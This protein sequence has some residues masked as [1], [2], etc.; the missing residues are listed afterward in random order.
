M[1]EFKINEH[2][3]LKLE[4]GI[5]NIYVN[6]EFFNQCK[7]LLFTIPLEKVS[8]YDEIGSIDEAAE[9]LDGSMEGEDTDYYD[10]ISPET[11]FWGHCSV[12]HEAV[13]LNAET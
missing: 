7:F 9:Q 12:R 2:L 3:K 13:W 11:I 1:K 8:S 6:N 5:T 4:D 10:E